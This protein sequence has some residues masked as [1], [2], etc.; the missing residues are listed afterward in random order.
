M[1]APLLQLRGLGVDLPGPSGRWLPALRELDLT[2]ARGESLALVGESGSGKTLTG[3]AIMGL[4]PDGA[5]CR[6]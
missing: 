4:L 3:L 5:R 6:G 1:S 2:L